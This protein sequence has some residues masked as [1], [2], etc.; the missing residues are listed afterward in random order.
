MH[1]HAC[2]HLCKKLILTGG[3]QNLERPNVERSIFRNF[4]ISN[5][6]MTKDELFD[7]FIVEFIFFIF[8][9]LFE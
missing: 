4:E 1:V 3:G 8:H 5:I 7:S 9:K 2:S 6:K